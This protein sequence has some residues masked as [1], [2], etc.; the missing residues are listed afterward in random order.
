MMMI[1]ITI[2]GGKFLFL[3]LVSEANEVALLSYFYED[4]RLVVL[5]LAFEICLVLGLPDR[6][7]LSRIR[8]LLVQLYREF[9]DDFPRFSYPR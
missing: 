3:G 2:N 7:G 1:M 9:R 5:K 8:R 4:L 6:R